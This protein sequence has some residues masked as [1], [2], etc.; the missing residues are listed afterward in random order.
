MNRINI[1]KFGF[2][3]GLTAAILYI[4][5]MVV[6]FTAGREGTID[7]FNSLLHGLDTTSIIRMDVPFWE[8]I[9]GMIQTFII[10]WL[11]GA[12]IAAFYNAQLK[13]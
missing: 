2:A 7:F 10:G 11:T 4:G 12:L 8:A 13:R 1:K 9:I 3:F 6:M 5:C